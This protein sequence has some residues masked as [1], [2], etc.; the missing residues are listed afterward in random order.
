MAVFGD[1]VGA[2]VDGV[3]TVVDGVGALVQ[4][5]PSEHCTG[6][7][8]SESPLLSTKSSGRHPS[9]GWPPLV[10]LQV[11]KVLQHSAWSGIS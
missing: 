1:G 11:H 7:V 8:Q 10:S 4:L 5:A 2:D 9:A 3:G 6:E